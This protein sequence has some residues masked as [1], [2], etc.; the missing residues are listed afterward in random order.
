MTEATY[1]DQDLT[2][3]EAF[4]EKVEALISEDDELGVIEAIGA[5]E[6]IKHRLSVAVYEVS[7]E[8]EEEGDE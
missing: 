8:D 7:E 2:P 3:V 1:E 5:L 6:L 4:M